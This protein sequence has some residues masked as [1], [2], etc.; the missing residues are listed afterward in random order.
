[1]RFDIIGP[2]LSMFAGGLGMTLLFTALSLVLAYALAVVLALLKMVPCRPLRLVLR[3]Y[4]SLFRGI[5][6]MVLLFLV[7]FATPQ[8]TGY[9]ITALQAGVLTFGL[10]GAATMSEVL[11][12]G[13]QAV[14]AGQMDA[15]R[16]LGAGYVR[17]MV[18]VIL[19]QA[20][21][22]TLPAL[23]N[24]TITLLKGSSLVSTIGVVDILKTATTIQS[25]TYRSFEP[26]LIAAIMYYVLVLALSA[27]GRRLE[28]MVSDD[29]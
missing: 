29:E 3:F 21:R 26:L 25:L 6:L 5:P 2:Y 8:L 4:T 13:I 15:A 23:V 24:E 9:A 16:A 11:R 14:P 22:S 10:N 19:P 17:A 1:M 12:G 7:Y 20:F 28:R 27:A 18:D